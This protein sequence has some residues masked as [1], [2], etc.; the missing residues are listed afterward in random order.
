MRVIF[1]FLFLL[2]CDWVG[3][4]KDDFASS[5]YNTVENYTG[6]TRTRTHT[7]THTHTHTYTQAAPF[8]LCL[9]SS[10]Q[11]RGVQLLDD[12]AYWKYQVISQFYMKPII[13]T[14]TNLFIWSLI[15]ASCTRWTFVEATRP[16]KGIVLQCQ[17]CLLQ[18][19]N[20]SSHAFIIKSNFPVWRD[21]AF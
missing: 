9:A 18:T 21:Q 7:H 2:L 15:S 19:S 5:D 14:T 8:K 20:P 3:S 13:T 10:V 4:V 17:C 16:F 1:Y 11:T 12:S 6:L